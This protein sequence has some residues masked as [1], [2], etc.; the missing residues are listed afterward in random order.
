MKVVSIDFFLDGGTAKIVT[1]IGTFYLDDRL[2]TVT[3]GRIY[4]RYPSWKESQ[5]LSDKSFLNQLS[6]AILEFSSQQDAG[7]LQNL[8]QAAIKN[9]VGNIR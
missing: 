7:G 4:D 8:F 5:I 1:D 2:G 6:T 9:L 3:P